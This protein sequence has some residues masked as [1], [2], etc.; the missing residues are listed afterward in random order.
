[1]PV[2]DRPFL[3]FFF[4]FFLF[5]FFSLSFFFFFFF[6]CAQRGGQQLVSILEAGLGAGKNRKAQDDELRRHGRPVPP[7]HPDRKRG[8]WVTDEWTN[9]TS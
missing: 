7:D 2:F 6:L 8:I 9:L 3:F 1:M 5:F 4:F